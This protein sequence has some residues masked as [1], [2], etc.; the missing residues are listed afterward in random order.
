ML[1]QPTEQTCVVAG[2]EGTVTGAAVTTVEVTCTTN[3]YSVGGN[4][5][6]IVAG[7]SVTLVINGG[8]TLPVDADGTFTF[9]TE[10]A[11]GTVYSVTIDNQTSD[12]HLC[13]L[14][15]GDGTVNGADVHDL[16]LLC[17]TFPIF[18]NGFED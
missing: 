1:T 13:T 18:G 6:G 12:A 8:E 4:A 11:S 16:V 14:A 10:L 2:G 3:L 17:R 5:S 7:E 15:N 9:G